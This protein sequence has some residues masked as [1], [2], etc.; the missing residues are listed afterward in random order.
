M[1]I[2]ASN[3]NPNGNTRNGRLFDCRL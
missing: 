3:L 2:L 1:A